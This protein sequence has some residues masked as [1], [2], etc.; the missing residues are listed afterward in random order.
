MLQSKC[1]NAFTIN[2]HC[3]MKYGINKFPFDIYVATNLIKLYDWKAIP[4]KGIDG[5]CNIRIMRG[6]NNGNQKRF[7]TM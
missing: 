4:I 3:A 5:I 7:R 1:I 2:R 6:Y